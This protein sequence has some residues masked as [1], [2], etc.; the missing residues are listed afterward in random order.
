MKNGVRLGHACAAV[1]L[2]VSILFVSTGCVP[3]STWR[4]V[5]D[6][7]VRTVAATILDLAVIDAIECAASV[8]CMRTDD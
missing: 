5:A 1:V 4:G 8:D 7:S 6:S 2:A 3:Q